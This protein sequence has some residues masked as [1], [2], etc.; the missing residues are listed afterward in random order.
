MRTTESILCPFHHWFVFIKLLAQL[1]PKASL[2]EI[3]L[4]QSFF[5]KQTIC[6]LCD[7]H[8]RPPSWRLARKIIH[9]HTGGQIVSFKTTRVSQITKCQSWLQ[10]FI[11][12]FSALQ[13]STSCCPKPA[14]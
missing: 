14:G 13:S 2:D 4:G 3:L 12:H 6:S 9:F 1:Y 5:S 10:K 8:L 11:Y 7:D